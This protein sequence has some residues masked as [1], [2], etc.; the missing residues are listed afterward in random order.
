MQ[1]GRHIYDLEMAAKY[2]ATPFDDIVAAVGDLITSGKIKQW[3]LSNESTYGVT[4]M[5]ESAKRQGVP[6][7]VS[8]QND[9]SITDR[10]ELQFTTGLALSAHFLQCASFMFVNIAL[11]VLSSVCKL[12]ACSV[13]ICINSRL[14]QKMI[15]VWQLYH[16]PRQNVS[17]R[18][19]KY[20]FSNA[21]EVKCSCFVW[22]LNQFSTLRN[23]A[24]VSRRA[25]LQALR[26]GSSRSMQRLW[27]QAT[28]LRVFERRI[29]LREVFRGQASKRR[30]PQQEPRVPASLLQSS[31]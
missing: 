8:I 10:C 23:P 28:L 27:S 21:V 4:M 22:M 17:S 15:T 29:P 1:F 3:G 24:K 7:P 5:C 25:L 14:V 11:C 20:S 31:S 19:Y 2:E 18:A 12:P 16:L 6:L 9:Y 13:C 30:A 26:L